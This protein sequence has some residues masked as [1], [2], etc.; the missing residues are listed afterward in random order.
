MPTGNQNPLFIFMLFFLTRK[1]KI[2]PKYAENKLQELTT[3]FL[4]LIPTLLFKYHPL[5]L[6]RSYNL[7]KI[8]R[9]RQ[10]SAVRLLTSS[11]VVSK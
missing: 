3:Y 1:Q 6:I 11:L 10:Q 4:A 5:S 8:S 7:T 2:R 9:E